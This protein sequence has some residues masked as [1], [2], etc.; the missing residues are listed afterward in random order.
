MKKNIDYILILKSFNK[1]NLNKN[2]A[3]FI[4]NEKYALSIESIEIVSDVRCPVKIQKF[5][6]IRSVHVNKASRDQYEIRTYKRILSFK[7]AK[8]KFAFLFDICR[9]Q[10]DRPGIAFSIIS[11]KE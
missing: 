8:A 6:T 5:T 3:D 9:Q 4:Y 11:I 7:C 10:M 2:V 1:D